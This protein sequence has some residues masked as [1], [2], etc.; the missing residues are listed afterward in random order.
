MLKNIP[1]N[2]KIFDP[3]PDKP[4]LLSGDVETKLDFVGI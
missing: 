4:F 2:V 3:F 1:A